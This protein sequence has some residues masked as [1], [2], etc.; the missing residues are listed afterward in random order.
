[1]LHTYHSSKITARNYS[2]LQQGFNI[3]GLSTVGVNDK[4]TFVE[5][6]VLFTQWTCFSLGCDLPCWAISHQLWCWRKHLY[7]PINHQTEI[8]S[9]FQSFHSLYSVLF[10]VLYTP[11]TY[12]IL[13]LVSFLFFISK[14]FSFP[15]ALTYFSIFNEKEHVL[16]FIR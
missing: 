1:M 12:S 8:G 11:F 2:L 9:M 4:I 14:P 7:L 15:L 3:D 16:R 6:F 13:A 5:R 10:T